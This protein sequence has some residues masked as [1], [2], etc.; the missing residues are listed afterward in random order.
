MAGRQPVL[1]FTT[2]F[3]HL[4]NILQERSSAIQFFFSDR[5]GLAGWIYPF[6]FCTQ[7]QFSK[8]CPSGRGAEEGDTK[9]T[10][11]SLAMSL[12]TYTIKQEL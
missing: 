11:L 10:Y 5:G 6:A 9:T 8:V 1:L 3:R 12:P 2:V 7:F 4:A